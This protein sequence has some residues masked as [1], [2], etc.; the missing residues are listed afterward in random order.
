[1]IVNAAMAVDKFANEINAAHDACLRSLGDAL[2][3][4]MH[5]GDLLEQAKRLCPHGAWQS[6]LAANFSGSSRSARAY[7]Q[8]AKNRGAVDQERQR[9]ATLSISA[10]LACLQA[11]QKDTSPTLEQCERRIE[12]G[13]VKLVA[14]F[15]DMAAIADDFGIT[16]Q[17]LCE[18]HGY[19]LPSNS[20]DDDEVIQP[21][22]EYCDTIES[23]RS[24]P[25][26]PA[27]KSRVEERGAA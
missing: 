14:V 19:G 2:D 3:H 8:L 10:A 5:A 20:D 18:L 27:A 24:A 4:A 6:W 11:P 23:W 17:Q 16:H 21:F 15:D 7:M 13:L 9:S 22:S 12:D 26:Y 1:M 25:W